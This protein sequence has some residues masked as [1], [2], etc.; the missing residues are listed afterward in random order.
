M[1]LYFTHE[2]RDSLKSFPL[3]ITVKTFTKLNLGHGDEVEIKMNEISRRVSRSPNNAEF[4]HFTLLICRGRQ[5]NVPRI[6][7]H[8]T[9]IVFLIKP[10]V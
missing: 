4:D 5:R 1:T 9:D 7:T 10:F 2:S 6:I 8:A 3:F